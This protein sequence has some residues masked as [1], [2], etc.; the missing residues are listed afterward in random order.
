MSKTYNFT[1]ILG[2]VND[3]TEG[4]EDAL[5]EAGC[6]DALINSRNGTV[7]LDFDRIADNFEDAVISAIKQ[8]ESTS[9]NIVVISVAPDDYV[10]ESEIAKR[11]AVNRQAISLW[12]RGARRAK[13]PFP[14]PVMKLTEK[15]PLW[16]WYE[17][18]QWLY[19]Q[20][21]IDDIEII[22]IAKCIETLNIALTERDTGIQRYRKKLIKRL[23]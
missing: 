15:S 16:R 18:A 7:Y 17:V 20:E 11:L 3:K 4:L 12:V 10:S 22:D 6:D 14:T 2:E 5:F 23:N 21:K 1:L 13:N 8:V 19:Q 9:L